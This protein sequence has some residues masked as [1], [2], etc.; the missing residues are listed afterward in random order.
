MRAVGYPRVSHSAQRERHTIE[1]QLRVIP[2]YIERQGWTLAK[3]L[4]TYIDDGRTAKAGKLEART[5]FARLVK[6]AQKGEFDVVVVVDL[7]RLTRSEDL[8]ER[9]AILGAF[10]RA[11]VKI[12]VTSS[13][14]L[15]D[16]SSSLG[17][18]YGSL[19]AFFAAEE[20]RKRRERS[21]QGKLTAIA[22]GNKPSGPTPYGLTYDRARRA[23]SLDPVRAPIVVEVFERVARG[24]SC[25]VIADDFDARGLPRVRGGRWIRER[26]WWI[27]RSTTY[28]GIWTADKTRKLE[29]PVPRI[30]EDE[31]WYA[32]NDALIRWGRR[33]LRRTKHVYLLEGGLAACSVCGARIGI[34]AASWTGRRQASRATYVCSHR[35]RPPIGG[36]RCTLPHRPVDE[37]DARVWKALREL[38]EQPDLLEEVGA[39][40]ASRAEGDARDWQKDIAGYEARLERMGR[41]EQAILARFRKGLVSETAMDAELAAGA[42]ERAM[43]ER[44]LDGAKRALADSARTTAD[45]AAL[46][47]TLYELRARLGQASPEEQRD[48]VRL[49]VEPGDVVL[50]PCEIT[51]RVQLR[52]PSQN[53]S[54]DSKAA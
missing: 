20:N 33:G 45:A 44:Q 35:R 36:E 53:V 7:D 54:P 9:G 46:K 51:A 12:A 4:S 31:L 37:V 3:P 23:W 38:L 27:A 15:L 10:Q 2:A 1:S 26:V 30:V 28:R 34:A 41:A 25:Q 24:E 47:A 11:G 16:L 13:G 5:G 40:R 42:R 52:A 6:D 22:R 50:S 48:L 21:V 29:V 39:E 17:D 32:A 8:A 14:Q 19:Q 18:L 49:L 43:L